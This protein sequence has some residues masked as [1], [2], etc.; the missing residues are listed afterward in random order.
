MGL[1]EDE[2]NA[3]LKAPPFVLSG[4][5]ETT[6][7]GR[8]FVDELRPV[9]CG[10]PHFVN[11]YGAHLIYHRKGH[12]ARQREILRRRKADEERERTARQKQAAHELAMARTQADMRLKLE[13]W[14]HGLTSTYTDYPSYEKTEYAQKRRTD[15]LKSGGDD[16]DSDEDSED[17]DGSSSSGTGLQDSQDSDGQDDASSSSGSDEGSRTND[18][19]A[20]RSAATTSSP[21][22]V[23]KAPEV[24]GWILADSLGGDTHDAPRIVGWLQ[25]ADGQPGPP[26]GQGPPMGSRP[27][28]YRTKWAHELQ[29]DHDSTKP[30]APL[31]PGWKLCKMT[32]SKVGK[33]DKKETAEEWAHREGSAPDHLT[34]AVEAAAVKGGDNWLAEAAQAVVKLVGLPPPPRDC[35]GVAPPNYECADYLP[36]I[37]IRYDHPIDRQLTFL[38]PEALC[39]PVPEDWSEHLEPDFGMVFYRKLKGTGKRRDA[40]EAWMTWRHPLDNHFH[41]L[42][43]HLH[44]LG[45]R[46]ERLLRP[47]HA[48]ERHPRV[49]PDIAGEL[50]IGD[51][52]FWGEIE[53][54][55]ERT[56][57]ARQIAAAWRHHA[58][59]IGGLVAKEGF[60]R[61]AARARRFQPPSGSRLAFRK[62]LDAPRQ[63]KLQ[64]DFDHDATADV[65][66][67]KLATHVLQYGNRIAATSVAATFTRAL[68]AVAISGQPAEPEPEPEPVAEEEPEQKPEEDE[69]VVDLD[70]KVSG[71]EMKLSAELRAAVRKARRADRKGN[72]AEAWALFESATEAIKEYLRDKQNQPKRKALGPFLKELLDRQEALLKKKVKQ[73]KKAAKLAAQLERERKAREEAAAAEEEDDGPDM[74]AGFAAAAK[75]AYALYIQSAPALHDSWPYGLR[76]STSPGNH[77]WAHWEW[78][79]RAEGAL[80]WQGSRVMGDKLG[81]VS[82]QPGGQYP[83]TAVSQAQELLTRGALMQHLAIKAMTHSLSPVFLQEETLKLEESLR[84][85]SETPKKRGVRTKRLTKEQKKAAELEAKRAAAKEAEDDAWNQA[86]GCRWQRARRRQL[87][88]RDAEL[89]RAGSEGHL[90]RHLVVEESAWLERDDYTPARPPDLVLQPLKRGRVRYLALH[91]ALQQNAPPAVLIRMIHADEYEWELDEVDEDGHRP[92][93]LALLLQQRPDVVLA[94]ITANPFICRVKSGDGEI[95]LHI[96]LRMRAPE[97]VLL[98]L[99]DTY[100]PEEDEEIEEA[101][102]LQSRTARLTA[103]AESMGDDEAIQ[104]MTREQRDLASLGVGVQVKTSYGKMTVGAEDVSGGQGSP[105]RLHRHKQQPLVQGQADEPSQQFSTGGISAISNIG[106]ISGDGVDRS[107]TAHLSDAEGL[108]TQHVAS[109]GGVVDTVIEE[110][111][112]RADGIIFDPQLRSLVDEFGGRAALFALAKDSEDP[113]MLKLASETLAMLAADQAFQRRLPTKEATAQVAALRRSLNFRHSEASLIAQY[114]R[115][116]EAGR[117]AAAKLAE[118]KAKEQEK[119]E[120]FKAVLAEQSSRRIARLEVRQ[121]REKDKA[122]R[123][124]ARKNRRDARTMT[125]LPDAGGAEVE[126][127]TKRPN[128][129]TSAY[130]GLRAGKRSADPVELLASAWAKN[131]TTIPPMLVE[132]PSHQTDVR[133]LLRRRKPK[134]IPVAVSSRRSILTAATED[135]QQAEKSDAAKKKKQNK[136]RKPKKGK[137]KTRKGGGD[138]DSQRSAASSAAPP[139][140]LV[141]V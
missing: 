93:H 85:E 39:A 21:T 94:L 63:E 98:A 108:L 23:P 32:L 7:E 72:E 22:K 133:V 40:D 34:A 119:K 71:P 70:E 96:A 59:L 4:S 33:K 110:V 134:L 129:S 11:H 52:S 46:M 45:G 12:G 64:S 48:R 13:R 6:F 139:R 67:S 38:A 37:S 92:L 19:A 127:V 26:E 82:L 35:G 103:M 29:G 141:P 61:R 118:Q 125:N 113:T 136:P 109:G 69:E 58:E 41:E 55:A 36:F 137:R 47:G 81:G 89:A 95:P 76:V 88:L 132:Q 117:L 3:A 24:G 107:I 1:L 102:A 106:D 112:D 140:Q 124:L 115:D 31:A 66:T 65:N 116:A 18:T 62:G 122:A 15:A 126:S 138:S 86:W 10:Q 101:E 135:L 42:V 25:D 49:A 68:V 75:T 16:L 60:L 84:A 91:Y 51:Q 78:D 44:S 123:A 79:E 27:W 30:P 80:R 28:R 20:E 90:T 73:E 9:V 43:P 104:E 130:I 2:R 5:P 100:H 54:D 56:I 97:Q 114:E 50:S 57:L 120:I 111:L 128:L 121:E 74:G 8:W 131:N 53:R 83:G 77:D 17:E 99:I 14:R 105:S 87:A